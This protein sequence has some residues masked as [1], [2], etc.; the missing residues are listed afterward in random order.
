MTNV[1]E[2][3][4][5]FAKVRY[6]AD[7]QPENSNFVIA[8]FTLYNQSEFERSGVYT[9]FFTDWDLAD[10]SSNRAGFNAGLKLSYVHTEPDDTLY[11]G[12]QVLENL[13]T[14]PFALANASGSSSINPLDGF[15]TEEK[16]FALSNP[17]PE[18]GLNTGGSDIINF[19]SAGPFTIASQESIRVAFAFH[20]ASN[21]EELFT[22]AVQAR[23]W[24]S[25][26]GIPLITP[27]TKDPGLVRL[28]PIP[29]S[30]RLKIESQ[31][32]IEEIEITDLIGNK[33]IQKSPKGSTTVIDVMGLVNGYYIVHVKSKTE[34]SSQAVIIAR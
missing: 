28:Y 25:S 24:F 14:I 33:L 20:I 29:A 26:V 21:E 16:Y 19:T 6:L 5:L 1:S 4:P 23:N 3:S 30:D 15:T 13:N 7:N 34:W 32:F 9:G 22:Q 27:E 17:S 31:E 10:F 2:T 18:A 12:V 8:E 11:V